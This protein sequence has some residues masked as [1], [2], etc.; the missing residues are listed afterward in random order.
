MKFFQQR[1][2]K[3][4]LI[5][6]TLLLS[7]FGAIT[8]AV[9]TYYLKQTSE[10]YDYILNRTVPKIGYSHDMLSEYRK[11]LKNLFPMHNK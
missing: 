1:S 2:L 9:G 6:I 5:M 8:G 3:A 4:K 10:K 11:L 7:S